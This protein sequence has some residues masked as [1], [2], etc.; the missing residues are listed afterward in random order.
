MG[1]SPVFPIMLYNYT[2]SYVLNMININKS[3]KLLHFDLLFTNK[4]IIIIKLLNRLNYLFRYEIFKNKN[5]TILIRVY[6]TYSNNT[7]VGKNFKIISKPSH[8]F[9]ISLASIS[10]LQKRTG[11]S[12]FIISTSQGLLTHKEAFNKNIGGLVLGFFTI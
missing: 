1:S 3:R 9:Y 11:D 6:L 4:T 2:F 10:L 8:K 12:V 5:K 7:N